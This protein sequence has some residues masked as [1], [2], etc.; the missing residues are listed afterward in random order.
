MNEKKIIIICVYNKA[1]LIRKFL[2]N[3]KEIDGIDLLIV[4]DGS[5]DQTFKIVQEYPAIK[6]IQRETNRG[7]GASLLTGLKFAGDYDY[8]YI[9]TLDIENSDC[10]KDLDLIIKNLE[11]GYD[12]VNLSRILENY[13]HSKIF[14]EYIDI[15][16]KISERINGITDFDLT[17]PLSGIMG[18]KLSSIENMELTEFDHALLLQIWIQ[19]AYYNLSIIEMPANEQIHFGKEL[20]LYEDPIGYFFS[21]IETE[22]YLYQKGTIN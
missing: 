20:I 10:K 9:I 5:T 15:T 19:A 8:N 17:D 4:D 2:K 21:I 13:D 22:K 18:I 1:K 14:K 6:Y 16:Q 11:Y 3:F 12:V 7:F